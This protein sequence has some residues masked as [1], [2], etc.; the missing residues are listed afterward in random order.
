MSINIDYHKYYNEP[1]PRGRR[2]PRA[3]GC[4]RSSPAGP[5]QRPRPP[6]KN[7]AYVSPANQS[8]AKVAACL[9]IY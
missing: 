1:R 3:A 4:W 6:W 2:P 7:F 8:C 9:N 5:R